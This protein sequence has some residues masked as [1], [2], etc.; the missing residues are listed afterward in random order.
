MNREYPR[1]LI[2]SHNVI[3]QSNNV[4]KTVLSFLDE[5]PKEKLFSLYFRREMPSEETAEG[6]YQINDAEV[7]KAT[8]TG[9]KCGCRVVAQ[10]ENE[11]GALDLSKSNQTA[12][13]IGNRR[14]SL[15]SYTRDLVWAKGAWKTEEFVG[16]LHEI[17]PEVILFIPNDYKLAFDVFDFVASTLGNI[18]AVTFFTDDAFY[19]EQDIYGIDKLRRKKLRVA[20]KKA[21]ERSSA[22]FTT[23][24]KMTE[25]YERYFPSNY[26]EIGNA[27]NHNVGKKDYCPL[28][29]REIRFSYIGNL[30]SKRWITLLDIAEQ[31][32]I[33]AGVNAKIH[34]FSSSVLPKKTME[35][36]IK[37]ECIVWEGRIN[38]SQVMQEQNKADVLIHVESFDEKSKK[39][40][41]LS[42]STKI[43]E[44]MNSG[45]PIFAYGPAEIASIEYIQE[46]DV[47]RVC[48]SKSEIEAGLC[49]LISN[50]DRYVQ[51]AQIAKT[52]AEVNFTKNKVSA[53]FCEIIWKIFQGKEVDQ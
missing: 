22:V 11:K 42:V 36:I 21:I 46:K 19:F 37:N 40:T 1:L 38:S 20:G 27:V 12:Y 33:L 48:T 17:K 13:M 14:I 51:K 8:L 41:R 47:A 23:C 7:L 6:F 2:I 16:W 43:F 5:W 52:Y 53:K 35:K 4:G 34:I 30:H 25:E 26:Y 45:T 9:K 15:I 44:Y 3:E 50:Y 18:P 10:I 39:S 28:I 24:K 29:D 31:L 32:K 49:D